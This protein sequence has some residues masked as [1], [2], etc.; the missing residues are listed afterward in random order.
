MPGRQTEQQ[1]SDGGP[2]QH[3]QEVNRF[4]QAKREE[5]MKSPKIGVWDAIGKK[6][7]VEP[8]FYEGT[9]TGPRCLYLL[10][11]Q[12]IQ[13]IE[14]WEDSDNII[15]MEDGACYHSWTR[16]VRNWLNENF[17]GELFS[18]LDSI[19]IVMHV[20]SFNSYC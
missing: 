16:T 1:S 15:L 2:M 13:V 17:E 20:L 4:S 14:E 10:R 8:F 11:N 6:R 18:S 19:N 7:I 3:R 5:P 12:F 9:M